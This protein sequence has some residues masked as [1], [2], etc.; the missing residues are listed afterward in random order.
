VGDA[1]DY[2]ERVNITTSKLIA[3]QDDP[4]HKQD[5]KREVKQEK[6]MDDLI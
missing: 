4:E 3:R 6:K 1:F 2:G 5:K